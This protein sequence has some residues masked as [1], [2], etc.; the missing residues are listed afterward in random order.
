[1]FL[2]PFLAFLVT[3]CKLGKRVSLG[4][5]RLDSFLE[6]V[7]LCR[8]KVPLLLAEEQ[9]WP[10]TQEQRLYFRLHLPLNYN[11]PTGLVDFFFF[12]CPW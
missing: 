4:K 9:G 3:L 5:S 1:M 6:T 8:V 7:P 11:Q 12:F 2:G 10:V